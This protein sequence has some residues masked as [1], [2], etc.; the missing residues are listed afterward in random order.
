MEGWKDYR[1]RHK[2]PPAMRPRLTHCAHDICTV[3]WS[4]HMY[5]GHSTFSIHFGNHT[6]AL[7]TV[8]SLWLGPNGHSICTLDI[9]QVLW[10]QYSYF[11][12]S[13][14]TMT[15]IHVLWLPSIYRGTV[16]AP[17][18]QTE[19]VQWPHNI[20]NDAYRVFYPGRGGTG[21][22]APNDGLGGCS[23]AAG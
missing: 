4:G 2:I 6:R 22:D 19:H 14:C 7:A 3:R 18:P 15:I 9:V 23:R 13:I 12:H 10:Q 8:C 1:Q 16:H 11:S 21:R 5:D 20:F 17:W